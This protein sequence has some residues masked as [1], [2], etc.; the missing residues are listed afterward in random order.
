MDHLD[1]VLRS[2]LPTVRKV[3][4]DRPDGTRSRDSGLTADEF[5]AGRPKLGLLFGVVGGLW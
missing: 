5:D 1:P 3:V 4:P 2:R